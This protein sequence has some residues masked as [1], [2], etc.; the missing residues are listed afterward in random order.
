MSE[1]S[2]FNDNRYRRLYPPSS[3]ISDLRWWNNTLSI[4]G[5]SRSLVPLGPPVNLNLFVDAS[6]S[7]GIGIYLDGKWDAWSILPNWKGPCRDIGWLEGVGLEFTIYVLE[8][9]G[10]SNAHITIYSDNKGVIGAFDKGR[11]RNFKINSSIRRSSNVL[12]SK[13][14]LLNLVHVESEANL[15]DPISRGIL[16]SPESRLCT[17]FNIPDDIKSFFLHV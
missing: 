17:Q 7:W 14:I 10:F 2:C 1:P 16:G 4:E 11:C 6:T 5:T 13:N 8:E 12:A 15:A 9:L 3:V